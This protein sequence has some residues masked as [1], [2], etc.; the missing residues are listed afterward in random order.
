MTQSGISQAVRSLESAL[1]GGVLL[2][3]DRNGVKLTALGEKVA[4]HARRILTHVDCIR[5]EASAAVG[6]RTGKVR[7]ASVASA[8]ARL[9]PASIRAFQ[10]QYP[11]IEIVLVEATDQEGCGWVL[12]GI[13]QPGFAAV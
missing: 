13:V 1:H 3:R 4:G 12:P 5:Q 6:I 11:H 10:R 8:A 9:L 7:I 2:S